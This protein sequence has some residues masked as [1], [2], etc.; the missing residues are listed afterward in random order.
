MK[1][2][3]NKPIKVK[4]G[5]PVSMAEAVRRVILNYPVGHEFHGNELH[6]DVARLYP[7]ARNMYTDTVQRAMRRYC[8][9][10]V[11][12]VKQNESLYKKIGQE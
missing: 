2:W 3:G 10:L 5:P 4:S 7:E 9:H 12:C 1:D 8:R 6:N 11:K